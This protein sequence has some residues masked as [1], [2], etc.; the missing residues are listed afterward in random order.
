VTKAGQ[1]DWN[2]F[3]Y[4]TE[5]GIASLDHCAAFC[6][7][8]YVTSIKC[9]VFVFSGGNCY[10]GNVDIVTGTVTTPG[11]VIDAYYDLGYFLS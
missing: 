5:G 2:L 11:G 6:R 7:L 4:H 1:T 3:H 9:N 10:L 8:S